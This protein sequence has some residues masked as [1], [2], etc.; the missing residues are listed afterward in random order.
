MPGQMLENLG[1]KW[2]QRQTKI[3]QRQTKRKR[4][5]ECS[6]ERH[7][8][9]YRNFDVGKTRLGKH[10]L[11]PTDCTA[12][13]MQM[14]VLQDLWWDVRLWLIICISRLRKMYLG[15]DACQLAR[16]SALFRAKR[17]DVLFLVKSLLLKP[18]WRYHFGRNWFYLLLRTICQTS[19][20][21]SI[22]A[23]RTTAEQSGCWSLPGTVMIL[24]EPIS[25]ICL[26]LSA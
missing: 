1:R 8:A 18:A 14:A 20:T 2:K 21:P 13:I 24:T 6:W 5:W 19:S 10:I 12:F 15:L 23:H 22:S 16:Y 26:G 17:C 7:W 4:N 3:K 9:K 25:L 11:P